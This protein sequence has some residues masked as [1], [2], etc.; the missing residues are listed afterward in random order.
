MPLYRLLYN[1]S[2]LYK[3]LR[4]FVLV[5]WMQRQCPVFEF[6]GPLKQYFSLYLAVSQKEGETDERKIS[7]QHT[8]AHTASIGCPIPTIFQTTAGRPGIK[9]YPAAPSQL[10]VNKF[11]I[12]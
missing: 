11:E 8:L 7:K 1:R 9:I 3:G 5:L 6:N 10:I 12:C 2:K 4:S